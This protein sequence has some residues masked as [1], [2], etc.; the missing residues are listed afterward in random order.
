MVNGQRFRTSTQLLLVGAVCALAI[1]LLARDNVSG[2]ANGEW[3][4]WG[5]D[6]RSSRYSPLDQISAENF[7]DLVNTGDQLAEVEIPG[8]TNTAPMTFMHEGRQYIVV[9]IGGRGVV[10]QHVALVLP[11]E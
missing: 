10:G 8:P 3:R 7:G 5:G 9:S 2:T 1:P 4:Y 6:E 11:E